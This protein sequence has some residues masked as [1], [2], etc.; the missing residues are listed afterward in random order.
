[1]GMTAAFSLEDLYL[2]KGAYR[3][4]SRPAVA[5]TA[6][7]CTLAWAGGVLPWLLKARERGRIAFVA[8]LRS[9]VGL[10]S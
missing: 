1:M 10:G 9:R 7:G 3:G 4:W 5:A 8:R 6:V 2:E